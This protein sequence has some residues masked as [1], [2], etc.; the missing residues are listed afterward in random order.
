[1]IQDMS[2]DKDGRVRE[3]SVRSLSLTEKAKPK[4][5]QL[6]RRGRVVNEEG[7]AREETN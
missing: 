5:A 3:R 4:G 2:R 7:A 6:Q 1:M